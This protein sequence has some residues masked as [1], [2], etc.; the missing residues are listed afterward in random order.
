MTNGAPPPKPTVE[1]L[2]VELRKRYPHL[3]DKALELLAQQ[4][5]QYE[6]L[7][8]GLAGYYDTRTE[9]IGIDPD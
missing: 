9:T 3:S 8:G 6:S 2:V 4:K 7:P 5:I 1:E